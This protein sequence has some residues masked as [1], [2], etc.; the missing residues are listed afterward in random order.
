MFI[1]VKNVSKIYKMDRVEIEAL[2]NVSLDIEPGDFI[3]LMGPSGAG[4][5]T[6]LHVIGCIENPTQGDVIIHGK[7]VKEMNDGS[8]SLFRNKHIGFIF[9]SF[10]LLP[11]LT[12]YENVEYPLMIRGRKVDKEQVLSV[13]ES[14]G[15]QDYIKHRPDELSG[16][17]RQRV[18]VARSIVTEPDIIIADEPTANLDSRT[19]DLIIDLLL[20][21]NKKSNTAFLFSTHNEAVSKYAKKIIHILDGEFQS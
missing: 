9:Q 20:K 12:V 17:Q 14:V 3:C 7:N 6:L 18:A 5:S 16:G 11:V 2:K 1:S 10:N 8:L 4:K 13:I 19:G 21:L 15:L